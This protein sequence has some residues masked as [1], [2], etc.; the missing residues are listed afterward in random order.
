[1]AGVVVDAE[2]AGITFQMT[3]LPAEQ[4][5][6]FRVNLHDH[7]ASAAISPAKTSASGTS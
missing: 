1:M 5:E 6:P 2:G 4:G 3:F 7:D